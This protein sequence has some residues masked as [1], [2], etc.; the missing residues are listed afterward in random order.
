[1]F[2]KIV[3]NDSIK[4]IFRRLLIAN[5]LPN[6]LLLVGEEGVGKRAFALETAKAFICQN[7]QNGEACDECRACQRAS[8]F[9]YPKSDDRDAHKKVIFSEHPDIGQ[10]IPYNRNIFVDA[11]RELETETNFLPYE[12][13]ARF[14]LID[15]AEKMNDAAANALLKTLEEPTGTSHIFL[16]T[17]HPAA[18]LPT[19]RSRCQIARFAPVEKK[20]IEKH[21]LSTKKFA[22]DDAALL[23]NLSRGSIGRALSLDLQKFREQREMMLNI[24]DS[25]IHNRNRAVLLKSAE[26]I[27]DAKN[28]DFYEDYLES[29]QT[30]IHDVWTLRLGKEEIVNVDLRLQL[31]AL[32][33]D[34]HLAKLAAWTTNIEKLYEN[35]AV[36]LN[37]K[38]ATD[39]LFM[40]MANA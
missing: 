37:K 2:D 36:N 18:L 4:S 22:H 13:K 26:E 32:A 31:L 9:D 40:Q 12:A 19:I 33:K 35:L 27:N 15:D 28:K 11:I 17:A 6:S 7:P 34:A 30:L 38:I 23:A 21:L 1:M 16:I 39:A 3:G 29:L 5:R 14:F 10:V 24:L 8:K 25:L 20:E